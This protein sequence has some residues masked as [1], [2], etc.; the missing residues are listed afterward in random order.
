MNIAKKFKD[1]ASKENEKPAE[2]QNTS[3]A[4]SNP[5]IDPDDKNKNKGSKKKD[6]IEEKTRKS[7]ITPEEKATAYAN[8]KS[9]LNRQFG[10]QKKVEGEWR[11]IN[12]KGNSINIDRLHYDHYHV[13]D[14]KNFKKII[15]EIYV[16]WREK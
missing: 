9:Q 11:W 8:I 10:P 12:E 13:F 4:P 3:A 7:P 16:D 15:K 2:V 5:P 14:K 1:N 6:E